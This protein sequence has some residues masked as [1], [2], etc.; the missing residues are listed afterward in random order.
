MTTD[1]AL[2]TLVVAACSAFIGAYFAR[3]RGRSIA[4]WCVLA[5]FF[6]IIALMAL[7][8]LPSKTVRPT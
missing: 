8:V 7:A 6:P 2:A 3:Y 1:T 4:L 5:F